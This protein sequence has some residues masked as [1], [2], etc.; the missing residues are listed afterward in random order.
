MWMRTRSEA[1]RLPLRPDRHTAG[2]LGNV[3]KITGSAFLPAPAY[4]KEGGAS[5]R[6]ARELVERKG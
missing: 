2:V 4:R 3:D 1:P 5:S 6:L